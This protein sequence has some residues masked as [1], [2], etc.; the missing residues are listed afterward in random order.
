[1]FLHSLCL[2]LLALA[3]MV[4]A[5]DYTGRYKLLDVVD[6][7]GN[8]TDYPEDEKFF[9]TL[10]LDPRGDQATEYIISTKIGNI[11]RGEVE[12]GEDG[13]ASGGPIMSTKMLPPADIREL[14]QVLGEI[15]WT[16]ND[17][18]LEGRD[19]T[20]TGRR[21]TA[22]YRKKKDSDEERRL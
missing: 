9:L 19:L 13:T 16:L 2:L 7:N 3:P 12:I 20:L 6:Q 5:V 15:L 21:G 11:M 14:E 17:I 22:W 18:D 10:E 4:A 8:Q 1:M